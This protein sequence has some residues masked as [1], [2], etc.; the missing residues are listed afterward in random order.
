MKGTNGSETIE[1]LDAR[2]LDPP[3]PMVAILEALERLPEESTLRARTRRRPIH[4][5]PH[6]E[7]RGYNAVTVEETD[8]SYTTLI[9]RR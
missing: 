9:N 5:L 8:G 4:L 7:E 1:E 6:L 3:L 2:E